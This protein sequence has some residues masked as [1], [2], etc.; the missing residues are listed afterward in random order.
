MQVNCCISGPCLIV[1]LS[2]EMDHH[3][4]DSARHIIDDEYHRQGALHI[5]FDCKGINFVDS[6]GLGLMMGRYRL[7]S[8]LDG[9][10]MVTNVSGQL[11]RILSL[12][13]LYKLIRKAPDTTS[14]VK[15]LEGGKEYV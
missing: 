13:G 14:A 8:S 12:S 4:C 9:K 11:D 6:S 10:V 5:I 7:V 1:R 15:M 2:G 3:S